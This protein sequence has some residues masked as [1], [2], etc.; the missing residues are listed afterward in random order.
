ML[1]SRCLVHQVL[2]IIWLHSYFFTHLRWRPDCCSFNSSGSTSLLATPS[3]PSLSWSASLGHR[4]CLLYF[5]KCHSPPLDRSSATATAACGSVWEPWTL[6]YHTRNC[7]ST[8]GQCAICI[9]LPKLLTL[10]FEPASIYVMHSLTNYAADCYFSKNLT[11][12][13]RT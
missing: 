6:P 10:T 12:R 4:Q 2:W 9:P 7:A 13:K 1:L 5:E 11:S 3:S 8:F